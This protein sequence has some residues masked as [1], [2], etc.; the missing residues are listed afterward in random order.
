VY[1]ID[2]TQA[3]SSD[4]VKIYV[5][6]QQVTSFATSTYPSQNYDTQVNNSVSHTIGQNLYPGS[7][8]NFNGYMAEVHFVDGSALT[9]SSFGEFNATTGVWSPIAY[10]GSYGTNGFYLNF[11]DN[12]S[13]TTLGEDQAQVLTI[14]HLT[15]SL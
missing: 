4:R 6:G 12:T 3:T 2:T 8:Q 10:A 9:P 15:T 7:P 13:T 1:S 11:S 14:G 5:N